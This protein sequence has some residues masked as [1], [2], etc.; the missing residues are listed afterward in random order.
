M[1]PDKV[2][3]FILD[4]VSNSVSYTQDLWQWG[5]DG[6][7]DTHKVSPLVPLVVVTS[8]IAKMVRQTLEGFFSSCAESGPKGCAFARHGST[9][10]ELRARLD[11]I[12][13]KLIERPLA[14]GQSGWGPG[15]VTASDVHYTVSLRES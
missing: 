9:A 1:F 14:V 2:N 3:R 10:Q 13:E 6:M 12:Y 5:F 11:S 8:L 7:D 15:I 4:G